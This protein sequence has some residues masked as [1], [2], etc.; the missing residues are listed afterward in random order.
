[1]GGGITPFRYV[2]PGNIRKTRANIK[3]GRTERRGVGLSV[4]GFG[5]TP[6]GRGALPSPARAPP[7]AAGPP[8]VEP[9]YVPCD[10]HA[11]LITSSKT[12][13]FLRSTSTKAT[14]ETNTSTAMTRP[15]VSFFTATIPVFSSVI[16][17]PDPVV[18]GRE[19]EKDAP[20]TTDLSAPTPPVVRFLV[21]HWDTRSTNRRPFPPCHRSE[22]V[23]RGAVIRPRSG[24]PEN[25]ESLRRNSVR[26]QSP[27]QLLTVTISAISCGE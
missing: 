10:P 7:R 23:L 12:S 27:Y 8:G 4:P 19:P 21:L 26:F 5:G 2:N 1:M 18:Q 3:A 20:R 14:R 25:L 13:A 15:M 11:A 24:K 22:S 16:L 17:P 6:L 9:G